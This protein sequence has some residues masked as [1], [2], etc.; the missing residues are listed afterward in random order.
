MSY[1][2]TRGC[3]FK[4]LGITKPQ[5]AINMDKR[6]FFKEKA[7]EARKRRE[8]RRETGFTQDELKLYKKSK[9]LTKEDHQDLGI[10]FA[11]TQ[12]DLWRVYQKVQAAYGK[13][14]K[15]AK[16]IYKIMYTI[17]RETRNLLDNRQFKEH[18]D[19]TLPETT[20]YGSSFAI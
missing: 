13:S 11:D 10:F 8:L 12:N 4:D 5:K 20:Y 6:D 15:E 17:S 14:S 1:E 7:P 19:I 3:I 16:N 9:S 18:P 2:I